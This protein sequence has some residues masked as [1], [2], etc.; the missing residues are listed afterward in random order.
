VEAVVRQ[1]VIPLLQD[2]MVVQELL[3]LDIQLKE[4]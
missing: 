4:K 1:M 2:Q 3:L